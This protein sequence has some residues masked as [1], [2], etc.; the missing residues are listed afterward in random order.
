MN[1]IT[2]VD[3]YAI[4]IMNKDINLPMENPL[5]KLVNYIYF[6]FLMKKKNILD[7]IEYL[8]EM[9]E[10]ISLSLHP[11]PTFMHVIKHTLGKKN[12]FVNL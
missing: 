7:F 6:S 3:T 9:K 10:M 5:S 11:K 4:D 1:G 12:I 2:W 8:V